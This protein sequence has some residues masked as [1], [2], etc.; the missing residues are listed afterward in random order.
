MQRTG[1]YGV[2]VW[3]VRDD[4][5]AAEPLCFG[6]RG[7]QSLRKVA[8]FCQEQ[9]WPAGIVD[10]RRC[11]Q[12]GSGTV[13]VG[14]VPAAGWLVRLDSVMPPRG[15]QVQA[16]RFGEV[17]PIRL[18]HWTDEAAG[19]PGD[20][21]AQ[22][23]PQHLAGPGP[24]AVRNDSII[25]DPAVL[26]SRRGDQE[27]I[28]GTDS[29]GASLTEDVAEVPTVDSRGISCPDASTQAQTEPGTRDAGPIGRRPSPDPPKVACVPSRFL[30]APGEPPSGNVPGTIRA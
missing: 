18:G 21:P 4:H 9:N 20:L 27:G 10:A 3:L 2:A 1:K 24:L 23:I 7:W 6:A 5:R 29:D 11:N 30:L 17:G 19:L 14:V 22:H 26:P 13:H 28:V 8:D 16:L 12:A 25:D 15:L